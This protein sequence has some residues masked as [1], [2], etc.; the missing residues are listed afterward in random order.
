LVV[1]VAGVRERAFAVAVAERPYAR[2][3]RAQLLV[4]HDEAALIDLNAGSLQAEIVGI[5]HAPDSQQQMRADDARRTGLA[6]DIGRDAA[7]FLLDRQ[8]FRA[9]AN[10]DPFLL[11]DVLYG[12]RHV[13]V[14]S[15]DQARPH[16][17]DSDAAAEAP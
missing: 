14:L 6:A 3:G 15:S 7:V 17:D 4:D 8:A 16:L 5:R 9:Q 12:L 2:R 13:L 1:V 11:E 10:L